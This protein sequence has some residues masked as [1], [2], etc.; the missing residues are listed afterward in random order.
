M[1]THNFTLALIGQTLI[2]FYTP[3]Y[4]QSQ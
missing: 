1:N 4:G 3:S 2:Y